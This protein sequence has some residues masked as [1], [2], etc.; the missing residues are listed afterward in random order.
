MVMQTDAA[1]TGHRH[2]DSPL[3][4][5]PHHRFGIRGK[6]IA[7]LIT[8][9]TVAMGLTGWLMI[10]QGQ[11]NMERIA[12]Q[13]RTFFTHYVAR[14]LV[15]S[16]VGHDY[17]TLQLL[18]DEM[19][20]THDIAYAKVLSD[21]N[22][23]MAESGHWP[24]SP[25]DVLFTTP[26]LLDGQR[27]G[28][29]FLAFDTSVLTSQI[30][31][32]QHH[33]IANEIIV[34][35]LIAIG[36]FTA[37]SFLIVRPIQLITRS[38][39]AAV[40]DEGHILRDIPVVGGDEIGRLAGQ[41]NVMRDHLN[42][43]NAKLRSRVAAADAQLH[44]TNETLRRQSEELKRVNEDLRRLAVTDPLTGLYN[45][46]QMKVAIE[47]EL[48]LT[49]RHAHPL[50]LIVIDI[51]HFKRINDT[52]GHPAGDRALCHIADLLKRELRHGD[53]VGRIGGEE[54]LVVC[55]H[56]DIDQ[57]MRV[58]EK[59]RA[60]VVASPWRWD[61]E[62]I[63]MTVSAGVATVPGSTAADQSIGTYLVAADRAL[64]CS[65]RGGRNR[66]TH[67]RDIHAA[68]EEIS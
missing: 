8:V 57:G 2:T 54:F 3:F 7:V 41:L 32:Q 4:A 35:L 66:T 20:K 45:Q 43:A 30:K 25:Q 60:A 28:Q 5:G 36:E 40:D 61:G 14:S 24:L 22:N 48:A 51:D 21:K 15:Y 31:A 53:I 10:H 18:L 58:A 55:R 52:Y 33:L 44:E 12:V 27:V 63:R 64:Y 67:A 62:D 34:T 29:V 13:R 11:Q 37:L 50:S 23:V 17:H 47:A 39:D 38:L 26:I 42:A 65:K 68:E 59:I 1:E 46:R 56:A 9:L 16:V 19:T 6:I 49:R